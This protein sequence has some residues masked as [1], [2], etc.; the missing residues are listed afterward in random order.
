MEIFAHTRQSKR[1]SLL[2]SVVSALIA[3]ALLM[4]HQYF[5]SHQQLHHELATQAKITSANSAAALVFNDEKA[6]RENLETLRSNP[7]ILGAAFYLG[8]GTQLATEDGDKNVFPDRIDP[9]DLSSPSLAKAPLPIFTSLLRMEVTQDGT[10]VGTLLLHVSEKSLYLQLLEYGIGLILVGLI[11]LFLASRFT[12]RLRKT[13]AITEGQLEQM[14]LYDNVTGLP[15]RRFFEHELRKALARIKR[16]KENAALLL[17]DVDN[18]KKVNDLCGHHAGDEVLKMIA[19]RLKQSVRQDDV[20]A[21]VGGDE[22]AAILFKVGEPEN[23]NAIA[24]AMIATISQ[25]FPTKPIPS[26][27]GLSIGMTIMPSDSEDPQ[28]LLRWSDMAMYEAKSQ[29]KNRALFFSKDINDKIRHDLQIEA[30]LREALQTSSGLYVAYQPQICAS[31]KRLIGVEALIRWRNKSG[32]IVSPVD[33][34]P[35]AEKTGLIIKIGDWMVD[36]ACQDLAH[37][38]EQGIDLPK[39]AINI[40]PYELTHGPAVVEKILATLEKHGENPDHFQLEL[41]E[42]ALM[43]ENGSAVL[44]AFREA[45]FSLAIDDFGAGYSSLGYLKRFQVSTLKIDRQFVQR[46][47]HDS[48]DA[49]II[50]AI[51][52]MAK[53]LGISIVAEGVETEAQ[54]EFLAAHDCDILQGYLLSRPL[55]LQELTDFIRTRTAP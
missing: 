41:T 35:V 7:R 52:Q 22:F 27:V 33:F 10:R 55:P 1:L 42:N 14:A 4:A 51:I 21:R 36:R 13:M 28:T 32:Q 19:G 39:I 12:A 54:A 44:N 24:N 25:P 30:E 16:E 8:N 29:G 26:H 37:L 45:G 47:P 40:S 15:N 53:A 6:A 2:T 20:I 34:I 9:Q 31:S 11:S 18:F 43:D 38:R 3:F 50:R 5:A 17:I 23:I 49:V 46:L 48:E